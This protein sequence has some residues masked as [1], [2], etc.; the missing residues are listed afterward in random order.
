VKG[1]QTEEVLAAGTHGGAR[2]VFKI[3]NLRP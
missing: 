3:K 1:I 2:I